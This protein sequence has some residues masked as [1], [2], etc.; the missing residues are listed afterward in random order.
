MQDHR[1]ETS[2][3]SRCKSKKVSQCRTLSSFIN[4][5]Q[6]FNRQRNR[7]KKLLLHFSKIPQIPKIPKISKISQKSFFYSDKRQV[8]ESED[9]LR[10]FNP[11]QCGQRFVTRNID[12]FDLLSKETSCMSTVTNMCRSERKSQQRQLAEVDRPGNWDTMGAYKKEL[13]KFVYDFI[14][15][16]A[17]LTGKA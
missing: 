10:F 9:C 16:D 6:S 8:N 15:N 1:L 12:P 14:G 4:G 2:A 17:T 7:Y 5:K 3:R 13:Y 11:E